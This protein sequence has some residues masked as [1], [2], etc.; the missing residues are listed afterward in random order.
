MLSWRP[1]GHQEFQAKL[2]LESPEARLA[3]ETPESIQPKKVTEEILYWT[4]SHQSLKPFRPE[5]REERK[6]RGGDPKTSILQ[7]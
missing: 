1:L 6:I 5:D 3:P 7:R 2:V 4:C